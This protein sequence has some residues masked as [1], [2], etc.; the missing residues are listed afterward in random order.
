MQGA[1]AEGVAD[2]HAEQEA[3]SGAW[4]QDQEIMTGKKVEGSQST[5]WATWVPRDIF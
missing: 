5:D 4:S 2:C 1:G 3:Q